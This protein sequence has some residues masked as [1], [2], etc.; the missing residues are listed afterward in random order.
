M[1]RTTTAFQC[2]ASGLFLGTTMVQEHPESPGKFLLPPYCTL[3][4]LPDGFDPARQRARLT[5]G[6]WK[7]DEVAAPG[8][9]QPL[10]RSDGPPTEANRPRVGPNEIAVI[11]GGGWKVVPDFR[12]K[13]YWLPDGSKH[14]VHAIGEVVPAGALDAPPPVQADP[15]LALPKDP[16]A[17]ARQVRGALITASDW[18]VLRAVELGEDVPVAWRAYRQALRDAPLQAGWPTDVRWPVAPDQ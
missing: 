5:R 8:A 11:I 7:I 18:L 10:Q 1:T 17:H 14:V 6:G 9:P 4:P 2:D 3:R 12:G 16:D 15:L 13:E